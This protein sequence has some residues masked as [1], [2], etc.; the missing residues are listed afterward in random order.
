MS[1]KVLVAM[2][3]GVDSS[4]AA[5]LLKAQ[6]YEVV[7]VTL[8]LWHSGDDRRRAGGCCAIGDISDARRVCNHLGIKHYVLNMEKEFHEF[9]VKNFVSEYLRG[10]TPN[11][12]VVCNEKIKFDI[13]LKKMRSLDFDFL[14]TGHYARIKESKGEFLLKKGKDPLKDQSYFLY[15]LTQ[16]ELKNLLFPVGDY[17]KVQIRAIARKH[18]LPVAHKPDSQEICFVDKDYASFLRKYFPVRKDEFRPGPIINKKGKILGWHRGFPF[19]TIGQRKGLGISSS[20]PLYVNKIIPEKNIIVVGDK[21][22]VF[23]R[24]LVVGKVT[25]VSDKKP[26]LPSKVK[27]KIRR[28]HKPAQAVIAKCGRKIEVR[29]KI[30]QLAVTPGQSAVFY[31][32]ETII[33][34][35]III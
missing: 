3:G 6:G 10:R 18:N 15:C 11:P 17:T 28:Q 25:W 2:S 12:C 22:D 27:V 19:Y 23:S 33:G 29:F 4:V 21:A 26:R 5:L 1:S 7:G 35:G 32:G 31:K 34:G 13:L 16:K 8:R 24:K 9:V 14:A 20:A 30:P